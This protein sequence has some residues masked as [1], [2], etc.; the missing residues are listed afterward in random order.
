[1]QRYIG[2]KVV[3]AEPELKDGNAGYKVVYE[4]GYESWCPK[5]VFEKHNRPTYGMP[6]S[7][8]LEAVKQGKKAAREGWNSKVMYIYLQPG[9]IINGK[10]DGRNPHLQQMDN[11]VWICSHI[12]MKAEDNVIIIGWLASQTDLLADDWIIVE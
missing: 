7:H 5:D 4:E 1:M 11:N 8:A 10:R 3:Q 6:F 12:D 9:S 2:V